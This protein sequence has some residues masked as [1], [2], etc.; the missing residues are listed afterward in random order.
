MDTNEHVDQ[1]GGNP[2]RAGKARRMVFALVFQPPQ[3]L[4]LMKFGPPSSPC[5][6]NF[7]PD[8]VFVPAVVSLNE[9]ELGRR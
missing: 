5:L 9:L 2:V 1:V 7:K 8:V 4:D 6:F 3:P